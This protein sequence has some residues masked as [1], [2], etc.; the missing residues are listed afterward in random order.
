VVLADDAFLVREAVAAITRAAP[1]LEL[2]AACH[3][4]PSLMAAVER[5]AA[6]VVVTDV[7]LPPAFSDEGIAA[8][9]ELRFSRPHVGVVVLSQHA[10]PAYVLGLF[11][12]GS[13]GRAYL[14]KERLHD[15]RDLV[16]AIRTVAAG[17]S[18]V[19]PKVVEGLTG[20]RS[21]SGE[22]PLAH[23]T[24]REREVLHHIAEGKGNP[25]IARTL[26]LSKR[27]VEKHVHSIFGKLGLVESED[28]S[29]RV[30]AALI[31]L[32]EEPGV[33]TSVTGGAGTSATGTAHP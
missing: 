22:S 15:R 27:S 9:A 4:L 18:V 12:S 21:W 5:T 31:F 2:A 19:D 6:D 25:A 23:L 3:D 26:H 13:E 32:A 30:M 20:S 17:G 10:D 24:G 16:N 1:G 33:R 8:A 7:R 11:A 28:M 14:L 29:R